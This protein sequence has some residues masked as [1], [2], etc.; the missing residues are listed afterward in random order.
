MTS[1]RLTLP[2]ETPSRAQLWRRQLFRSVP[3]RAALI[4]VAVKAAAT[5]LGWITP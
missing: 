1:T 5:V 3:G 2:G 4:G